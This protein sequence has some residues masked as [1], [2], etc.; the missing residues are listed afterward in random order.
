ML[1]LPLRHVNAL[2]VAAGYAPRYT[3]WSL[4]DDPTGM[5]AMA[6]EHLVAQHE[7]YPAFV[8]NRVYDLVMH[9]AGAVRVVSWLADDDD[10]LARHPNT[11]RQTLVSGGAQVRSGKPPRR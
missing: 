1:D 4:A 11:Y 2:L 9:N 3:Q 5:V 8:V 6:L 7:P 10:L